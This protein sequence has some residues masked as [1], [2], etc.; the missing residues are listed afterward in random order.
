MSTPLHTYSVPDISC[1]HCKRAIE[2]SVGPLSGVE[3]VDVDVDAKSV[4]VLGGAAAEV[5][6]AIAEAGYAIE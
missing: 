2:G 4:T 6:T 1:D 3:R 5:E